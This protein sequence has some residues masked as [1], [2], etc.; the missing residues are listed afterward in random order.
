M[1]ITTNKNSAII[2]AEFVVI[3]V[4]TKSLSAIKLTL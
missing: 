3:H 1:L 4:I 2:I